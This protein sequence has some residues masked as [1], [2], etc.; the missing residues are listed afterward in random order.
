MKK[1]EWFQKLAA[2]GI[3]CDSLK[4][5]RAKICVLNGFKSISDISEEDAEK[6]VEIIRESLCSHD[7]LF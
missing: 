2:N 5:I 1:Q 4:P 3:D 6:L 7:D